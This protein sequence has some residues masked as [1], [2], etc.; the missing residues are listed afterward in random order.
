MEIRF[1]K[2]DG[3][4][5]AYRTA[6]IVLAALAL[7][8]LW[9]TWQMM[10]HGLYLSGMNQRVPWGMQIIMAVFYIGLSAGSLI[11]SGLYGVF[12]KIDYKPFARL[13]AYIAMLFLIAGLLSILTDQGR[14]DR[15]F[16]EPFHHFNLRSMF[17]IN[18]SLYSG[19][20]ALCVLYLYALFKEKP[21]L[22]K[23]A[24]VT[25]VCWA[26]GVHSGTAAIFGFVP[27]EL[28][29]SPLLPASFVAAAL[30]SGAG[31]MIVLLHVL[32]KAT[33]R[34]LDDG[35]LIWL[36]K[37]MRVFIIVVCYLILVENLH[38][39]YLVES[40]EAAELFLFQGLHGV[41]FWAG[42]ATIGFVIPLVILYSRRGAELKWVVTAGVLVVF[43]VLCERYIIVIPGLVHPPDLFPGMR[44]VESDFQEWTATYSISGYEALQALGVMATWGLLFLLGIKHM[45]LVPMEARVLTE[46]REIPIEETETS[47]PYGVR[48][49]RA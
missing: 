48:A 36:G 39:F 34:R 25:V 2:V 17:S 1:Q 11:V 27:R 23:F 15:V 49:K 3:T 45:S 42:M 35:L 14:L 43:G 47:P 46:T 32:F 6:L 24:A 7:L 31:F 37:L 44:I 5:T 40:R 29:Q 33:R 22:T 8:G 12:G 20:I 9:A 18:P 28:Y 41:L 10:Q 16:K 26:I 4:S 21:R 13:A 19:H 30:A 38:R